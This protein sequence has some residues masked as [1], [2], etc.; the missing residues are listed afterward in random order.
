M[1]D[2]IQNRLQFLQERKKVI[3]DDIKAIGKQ[4]NYSY[5]LADKDNLDRQS[6]E[7]FQRLKKVDNEIEL[8]KSQSNL[9]VIPN[10]QQLITQNLSKINFCEPKKTVNDILENRLG[11]QGG[12]ALF[13]LQNTSLMRGDLCV[14]EIQYSLS[15]KSYG[16]F[17]YCPIDPLLRKDISDERSLLNAIADYFKPVESHPNDQQYVQNIID[18]ISASVQ[19]N[20]IVFFDFTNWD[21]LLE[22]D[23]KLLSWFIQYFWHP[24]N[25]KHQEISKN[26]ASVKFI[27][28]ISLGSMA[29]ES[30]SH[31]SY[32]YN[33]EDFDSLKILK[34][35]LDNWTEV[36][37]D[38]W[39]QEVYGLPMNTSETLA[40][41]IYK[42]S[43]P[44]IPITV[45]SIL[46][47]NLH[48][49]LKA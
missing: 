20:S 41:K 19:G 15:S 44:G 39:L 46:Q 28:F 12:T 2:Y 31:L 21:S 3:E 8:L 43:N 9:S 30:Y 5:N 13:L 42:L 49:L 33:S 35:P 38:D 16:K 18:Q 1:T 6:N 45:C 11:K 36:N 32:C 14:A 27:L 22:N 48:K 24:L 17:K 34:L 40:K 23:D 25:K 37:I 4:Y 47:N 10:Q 7:Y 26:Y 29:S